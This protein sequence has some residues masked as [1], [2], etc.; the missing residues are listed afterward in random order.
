MSSK[1][2]S[3]DEAFGG[4]MMPVKKKKDKEKRTDAIPDPRSQN[5]KPEASSSSSNFFP[6]P[7][8][9]ADT[10]EWNKA[11]T[12]EG[13]DLPA[14]DNSPMKKPQVPVQIVEPEEWATS[15]QMGSRPDAS[16]SASANVNGRS[17][18]WRDA[19]PAQLPPPSTITSDINNRLDDLSRKLEAFTSGSPVQSTAELFLFVAIGL[20]FLLAI[21]TLLRFATNIAIATISKRGGNYRSMY[22]GR[23]K[24]TK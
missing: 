22:G 4:P 6:L 11:F 8:E 1:F 9:T 14:P 7:G 13:S 21:D 18:L 17:T 5:G 15:L 19:P 2:C 16:A 23:R 12:L 10:E 3:L 24:W 20:V